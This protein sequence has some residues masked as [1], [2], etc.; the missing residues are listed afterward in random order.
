MDRMNSIQADRNFT[1]THIDPMWSSLT[2]ST[3]SSGTV[4]VSAAVRG[5]ACS[6]ATKNAIRPPEEDADDHRIV[7]ER[8][9][10]CFRRPGR[11]MRGL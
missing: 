5:P 7:R 9:G 1:H 4:I 10:P 6:P 2:L 11:G 8:K 3:A